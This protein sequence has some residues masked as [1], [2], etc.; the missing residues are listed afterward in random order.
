MRIQENI[1]LTGADGRP[2]LLDCYRP[3]A[4]GPFPVIVFAH[5]FKGFKDW[6]HWHL[7]GRAFAEAGYAFVKFNFS[8]NGTTPEQPTEFADLEAFGQNNYS[9]ELADLDAVFAWLMQEAPTRNLD[10]K[11]VALIGHSRGGGLAVLYAR[12]DPRVRLLLTWAAVSS[13]DYRWRDEPGA[14]Q[15]WK[16]DGVT[17]VENARTGQQMPL[18]FQLYEDFQAKADEYNVKYAARALSIPYL[19]LHGTADPAVPAA[20]ARQLAEWAPNG[21]LRLIEGADHVF[22]GHHPYREEGLP[23]HTEALVS[24]CLVFLSRL[25]RDRD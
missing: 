8:Y 7:I 4:G 3:E 9:R 6:G 23:P 10:P 25:Q 14:V 22:G 16:R 1:R 11:N 12:R 24:D 20:S 21:E 13:L 2:F 5:G 17:Y 15:R 19:V 18:Y